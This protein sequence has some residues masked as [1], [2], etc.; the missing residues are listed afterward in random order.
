MSKTRESK[1]V[2]SG[3]ISLDEAESVFAEYA[4]ADAK[5]QQITAKMDGEIVAIRDKNAEKLAALTKT[6][7]EAIDKLMAFAK[8]KP[9]LFVKKKSLEMTHGI[10]GFRTGTPSLKTIKGFTWASVTSMLKEF[11]PE[12]VR[13]VDEPAK[14]LLLANREQEDIA[15]NFAKCGF[16]VEQTESFFIEPKKEVV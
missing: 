5:V 15:K 6:K 9:E 11:M 7:E 1:P 14:D 13:T 8:S 16:K 10:I 3:E 12:F 2:L 4:T